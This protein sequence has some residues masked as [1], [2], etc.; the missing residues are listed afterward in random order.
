MQ[1]AISIGILLIP[2]ACSSYEEP[3]NKSAEIEKTTRSGIPSGPSTISE[4]DAISKAMD[5]LELNRLTAP[6]YTVD[7]VIAGDTSSKSK[8]LS[9]TLAYV[10]NFK[11]DS[12]YTVVSNDTRI[13]PVLAYSNEGNLEVINGKINNPILNNMEAYFAKNINI[14]TTPDSESANSGMCYHWIIEYR[15]KTSVHESS[16][17]NNLVVKEHP[18]CNAGTLP[19]CCAVTLS[20]T[21]E[22]LEYNN[23]YYDFPSINYCLIQGPGFAPVAPDIQPNAILPPTHF[24]IQFIYS[25]DGSIGAMSKLI[26][27]LGKAMN[28]SYST[29]NSETDP[30]KA[31]NTVKALGCTV[32]DF[33]TEYD[34][35]TSWSLLYNNYIIIQNAYDKKKKKY[36]SFIIDGGEG[37]YHS[38]PTKVSTYLASTYE[39]R[40]DCTS[41][42]SGIHMGLYEDSDY[43][44]QG[45]FGIKI[46]I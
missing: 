16:P 41:R 43:E 23:H 44:L 20:Y 35:L 45:F 15:I 2:A 37:I 4:S 39:T 5:Q 29:E 33:Y 27:D 25:Y 10:I 18:G 46:N 26:Y 17:Y 11:N 21:L 32:S 3:V 7:Y 34:L 8:F 40:S 22:N 13:D 19:T 9:D 6:A 1:S 30:I 31:Y 36:I 24:P 12:G 38:I 14:L 42:R 28:T